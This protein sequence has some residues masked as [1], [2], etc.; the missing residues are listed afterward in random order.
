MPATMQRTIRSADREHRGVAIRPEPSPERFLGNTGINS[1][2]TLTRRRKSQEEKALFGVSKTLHL[3][4]IA[5]GLTGQT[6]TTGHV[7][8]TTAFVVQTD[9]AKLRRAPVW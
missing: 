6:R 5:G 1:A 3:A 2:P 9:H 8:P 7:I 4:R